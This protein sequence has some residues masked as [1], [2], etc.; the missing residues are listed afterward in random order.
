MM[1]NQSERYSQ[2]L[3]TRKRYSTKLLL[4]EREEGDDTK[5]QAVRAAST[6]K[7]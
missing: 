4:L 5:P 7:Q 3:L 2:G 6:C 1:V